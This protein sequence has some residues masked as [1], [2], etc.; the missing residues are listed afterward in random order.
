[1]NT[2]DFKSIR[3]AF[4]W[5]IGMTLGLLAISFALRQFGG[6]TSIKL[7]PEDVVMG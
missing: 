1:M 2:E 4:Y 7:A 6:V 5:A 3:L